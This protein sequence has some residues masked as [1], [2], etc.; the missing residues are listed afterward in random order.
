MVVRL[1][2]ECDGC[3]SRCHRPPRSVLRVGGGA[4]APLVAGERPLRQPEARCCCS[5]APRAGAVS[6]RPVSEGHEHRR[7]RA[8]VQVAARGG[9]PRGQRVDLHDLAPPQ[10]IDQDGDPHMPA[11]LRP[12]GDHGAQRAISR[13]A[14]PRPRHDRD[15]GP[16]PAQRRQLARDGAARQRAFGGSVRAHRR[17]RVENRAQRRLRRRAGRRARN[18]GVRRSHPSRGPDRQENQ[19]DREADTPSPPLRCACRRHSRRRIGS[20]EPHP[21]S[22]RGPPSRSKSE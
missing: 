22:D 1:A 17:G 18:H 16:R 15:I 13:E 20:R 5:P 10:P 9:P 21:S 12:R 4:A 19:R 8:N 2:E 3:G 6:L 14:R 11:V 7:A